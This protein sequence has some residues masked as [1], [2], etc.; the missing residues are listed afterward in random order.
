MKKIIS[1]FI[2]FLLATSLQAEIIRTTVNLPFENGTIK[3]EVVLN[4]DGNVATIGTGYNACIPQYAEGKMHIPSTVTHNNTTYTVTA[5]AP[6]AFRFCTRLTE[7]EIDEGVTTI[8]NYAFVGCLDMQAISLPSTVNQIGGGAFCKL[9]NLVAMKCAATTPPTWKWYDVF[10]VDGSTNGRHE[11]LK[12]YVPTGSEDAYQA[13]KNDYSWTCMNTST[14]PYT[15]N[16]TETRSQVGWG[17]YFNVIR[18][19]EQWDVDHCISIYTVADLETFRDKVNDGTTYNNYVVKLEADLDLSGISWTP[20][21]RVDTDGSEEYYDFYGTFD[22]QGHT[23]SNLSV[24]T[25][26]SYTDSDGHNN[27]LFGGTRNAT[28]KNI[29]MENATIKGNWFVGAVI[30][31]AQ[32]STTVENVLVKNCNVT[33][34]CYTGGIIGGA[35]EYNDGDCELRMNGCVVEGGSVTSVFNVCYD[36]DILFCVTHPSWGAA[37]GLIGFA[38]YAWFTNCANIQTKVTWSSVK[39]DD[40]SLIEYIDRQVCRGALVGYQDKDVPTGQKSMAYCYA[41][42]H[43]ENSLTRDDY[44]N[45]GLIDYLDSYRLYGN[46][47]WWGDNRKWSRDTDKVA[48]GNNDSNLKGM[49]LQTTLNTNNPGQWAYK[50]NE[51]PWPGYFAYYAYGD[52]DAN[53]VVYM[54]YN[55]FVDKPNY[56]TVDNAS[57]VRYNDE[58]NTFT[59]HSIAI[60]NNFSVLYYTEETLPISERQI[61]VTNGVINPITLSAQS[62]GT[63]QV[64]T[65]YPVYVK[66]EN[67]MLV[68]DPHGNPVQA[69]NLDGSPKTESLTETVTSYTPKSYTLYLPYSI[70]LT[71]NCEVYEP[72]TWDASA[73]K[74]NF[75]RVENNLVQAY[76]PYYVLVKEGEVSL[77]AHGENLIARHGSDQSATQDNAFYTIGLLY[78]MSNTGV[79]GNYVLDN[80]QWR[81]VPNSDFGT[82]LSVFNFYIHNKDADP[83]TFGINLIDNTVINLAVS[84]HGD[85]ESGGWAF[86]SSPVEGSI[87]P[88]EVENLEGWMVQ[89]GPYN[90]DLYRFNQSADLEWENYHRHD[91]EQD[92]F[93]LVNGHGYLYARNETR[94]LT[95]RGTF[96]TDNTKTVDLEY[97]ANA[98]FGG[99]NLVG[100]PFPAEAN[101][102]QSYYKMNESGTD[103]EAELSGGPVAPCTG[104]MVQATAKGQNV[105]FD[106]SGGAK[107][108]AGS[109]GQGGLQLTVAKAGTKAIEDKAI[110]SFDEGEQLGKFIFNKDNAKLYF[111]QQGHDYAIAYSD[112][113]G[114]MPLNFKAVTNGEYTIKVSPE[115][116][117]LG[118]LHL[119]DNLTG[120][121]VDL[122]QTTEYTFDART[123]D[124][125]SRFRIV[126]SAKGTNGDDNGNF[127]FFDAAGDLVITDATIGATLQIIDVMGRVIRS[128]D[129][130][131]NISTKDMTAGIYMLRLFNGN[132]VKTQK[133]VIE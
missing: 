57:S 132:N 34:R 19:L 89:N 59:A 116:V 48:V 32:A 38:K 126:F 21:G 107:S 39:V 129:A 30:A 52:T 63:Q 121:D 27:G 118:Y 128:I 88:S 114:E 92:P 69:V 14:T 53:K 23:I 5:I 81:K 117:E 61:T 79:Q 75:E 104:I 83:G 106:K 86:I 108:R 16:K 6:V 26:A 24:G 100:N 22:G 3:V 67:N 127:A 122:L 51:L 125:A 10:Q 31:H 82:T 72:T 4:S 120:T 42:L 87:D 105:T 70:T 123:S 101:V 49:Q 56:L 7:V 2:A 94:T 77:N 12:L 111:A 91:T 13:A 78:N 29:I 66:D 43:S 15:W 93:K 85:S 115:N 60:D 44:M 20:I 40:S 41:H 65:E 1:T 68:L 130:A 74:L 47:E 55:V 64:T 80:N 11:D 102:S 9:P 45:D 103:I 58:N 113:Q 95:F 124:Y 90:Y 8:G 131:R 119:I 112:Q 110:V 62:N 54:P 71:G 73:G 37:G 35:E 76:K 17:S 133:I 33:G 99:W 96:N 98:A 97:D 28:V 50:Y 109:K 36:G 84:G 25:D 46:P 18:S